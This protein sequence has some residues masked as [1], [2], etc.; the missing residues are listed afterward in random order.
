MI[1]SSEFPKF[2]NFGDSIISGTFR[3]TSSELKNIPLKYYVAKHQTQNGFLCL[4]LAIPVKVLKAV[5]GAN[6]YFEGYRVCPTWGKPFIEN[7][8]RYDLVMN[9]PVRC[10]SDIPSI[11]VSNACS[12]LILQANTYFS[13]V[14]GYLQFFY[15]IPMASTVEVVYRDPNIIRGVFL[16]G[17]C[18]F[19]AKLVQIRDG[20]VNYYAINQYDGIGQKTWKLD[21]FLPVVGQYEYLLA[22]DLRQSNSLFGEE[23]N[24]TW[25]VVS[26]PPYECTVW[27]KGSAVFYHTPETFKDGLIDFIYYTERQLR[28]CPSASVKTD[29]IQEFYS[30]EDF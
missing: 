15:S 24:K 21:F 10:E 9:V 5:R 23:L 2:V 8:Y 7:E 6:I 19:E 22:E 30:S 26:Y 1:D 25:G 14:D 11:N 28:K 3:F 29:E 27:R 12:K 4:Y 17:R 16:D 13:R 18:R 20:I